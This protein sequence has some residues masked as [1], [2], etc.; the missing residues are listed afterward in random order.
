ML[1]RRLLPCQPL[2]RYTEQQESQA[3]QAQTD[4]EMQPDEELSDE[5]AGT[6]DEEN[7]A[8]NTTH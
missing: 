3:T 5:E 2:P 6:D 8:N 4:V 1:Q 7:N